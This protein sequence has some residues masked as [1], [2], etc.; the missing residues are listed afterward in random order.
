LIARL[1]RSFQVDI[2]LLTLFEVP[3]V[4]ELAMEIEILLIEEIKRSGELDGEEA[5]VCIPEMNF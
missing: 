1:R 5:K 2:R 4:A 3:T